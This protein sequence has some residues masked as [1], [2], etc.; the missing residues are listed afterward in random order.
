MADRQ[1]KAGEL[2]HKLIGA[3]AY[4]FLVLLVGLGVVVFLSVKTL[5]ELSKILT[6]ANIPT[7]ALTMKVMWLG[8]LLANHWLALIGAIGFIATMAGVAAIGAATVVTANS[9]VH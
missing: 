4:P 1:E 9:C 3:L 8:Q 5:P 7:P 6:D 2:G